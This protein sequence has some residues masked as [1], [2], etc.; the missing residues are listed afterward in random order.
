MIRQVGRPKKTDSKDKRKDKSI[1]IRVSSEDYEKIKDHVKKRH[2][3]TMSGF[4]RDLINE[5]MRWG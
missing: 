2:A 4:I 1:R 5:D 3:H